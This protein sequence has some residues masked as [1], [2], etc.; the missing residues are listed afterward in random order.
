[1]RQAGNVGMTANTKNKK[2]NGIGYWMAEVLKEADK[3]A[4]DFSADPVHDL[5]VA[6]RRCRSMADGFRALDPAPAW[7]KMKKAGKAVFSSLGELRDVQVMHEWVQ[8]LGSE[9][10]L[11]T[12]R[13]IDHC[14]RR[15]R[16]LKHHAAAALHSFDR[17]QWSEWAVELEQRARR[18]RPGGD[19][20]QVVALERLQEAYQLHRVA[21]RNRSK[22]AYHAVRIGLKK[23]RY[24]VENFL[25]APH[26]AWGKDLKEL[27]DLLGEVHDL[28]VLEDTAQQIGAYASS[29]GRARW[30]KRIREERDLRLKRYREKMVGRSSLWIVWRAGLP[31][32]ER[33]KKAIER[34]LRIWAAFLDP[35]PLHTQR[36]L[37]ISLQ[38]HD[39]LRR[40]G[41]LPEASDGI[42]CRDLLKTAVWGHEVG[43]AKSAQ[44]HHK[45]SQRL[46]AELD[47]PPGWSREQLQM[48][49]LIAR[50]HRG[51]LPHTDHRLFQELTPEHKRMV[52][53]L[54]GV[55]RLADAFD[56]PHNGL[57]HDVKL[58]KLSNCVLVRAPGYRADSRRAEKLA[59]ARHL[60]ETSCGVPILIRKARPAVRA[61]PQAK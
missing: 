10:D 56:N 42:P 13:L 53:S 28:D 20:F 48:A 37:R 12:Q 2:N 19:L 31:T 60:L 23:F 57:A 6:I 18:F 26:Q 39:G 16:E 61:T 43:R 46:I 24:M 8:K 3:A 27:Q 21:M 34:K 58:E 11:V 5:R 38:L 32:G 54:A 17:K 25:P 1:M 47:L 4:T 33:L 40:F 9:D 22:T 50:Y 41:L 14:V 52:K 36:V 30:R 44:G 49:A 7:R 35:D 29:K 55:L 15:E 51:A 45:R 59:A